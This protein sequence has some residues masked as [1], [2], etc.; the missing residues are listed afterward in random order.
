MAPVERKKPAAEPRRSVFEPPDPLGF[1]TGMSPEM[2][3]F[4]A[5]APF[6]CLI[7]WLDWRALHTV[8]ADEPRRANEA[9]SLRAL[10]LAKRGFD[11][12]T[13]GGAG[14]VYCLQEVFDGHLSAHARWFPT[15]LHGK[16]R[17]RLHSP[18]RNFNPQNSE[19]SGRQHSP[20]EGSTAPVERKKRVRATRPFALKYSCTHTLFCTHFGFQQHGLHEKARFRLQNTQIPKE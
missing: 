3:I 5:I 13:F 7:M 4:T 10:L 12:A 19:S 16:A 9:R 18:K 15:G 20:R 11:A 2:R 8:D 14:C 6:V 1:G 17:F